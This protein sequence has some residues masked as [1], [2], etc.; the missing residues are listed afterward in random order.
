LTTRGAR[1]SRDCGFLTRRSERG[2]VD[3]DGAMPTEL[4]IAWRRVEKK[5]ERRQIE[6]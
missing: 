2:L 1:A 5:L 6:L 4:G 3:T